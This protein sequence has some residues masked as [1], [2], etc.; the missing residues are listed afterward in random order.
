MDVP[1]TMRC[2]VCRAKFRS[3][4]ECTRCGAD[5]G[6]IMKLAAG[7]HLDREAARKAMLAL[8]FEKAGELAAAAQKAHATDPGRRLALLTSW[9]A[10]GL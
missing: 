10:A 6:N 7:A 2:P 9:L 1:G 3:T 8:N 5:L 4:R